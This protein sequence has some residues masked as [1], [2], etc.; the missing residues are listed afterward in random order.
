M[1]FL[2]EN[3]NYFEIHIVKIITCYLNLNYKFK[4]L[5]TYVVFF[6]CTTK[7][8]YFETFTLNKYFT[9]YKYLLISSS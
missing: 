5:P 8:A 9:N 7:Y 3:N 4:T 6:K 1:L 2:L